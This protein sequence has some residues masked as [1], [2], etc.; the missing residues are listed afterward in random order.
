MSKSIFILENLNCANCAS[1]IEAKINKLPQTESA[2]FA[3]TTKKLTVESSLNAHELA[4]I[5][6]KVCD[7][8]EYGV[9]VREINENHSISHSH[10][11]EKHNCEC[12]DHSCGHTHDHG[13]HHEHGHSHNH[14]HSHSHEESSVKNDVLTII[15]GAVLFII[16]LILEHFFTLSINIPSIVAYILAYLVLGR[17]ILIKSG[18]NILKGQIFD[19]NFL[20]SIATL[21]AFAIQQ[22]PEA[23]G[24]MLFFR[25]G[26]LFEEIAVEKSRK[27]I[28]EA[29]DL[30]PETVRI[31]VGDEIKELPAEYAKVGDIIIVRPGDR[32][33]L[34]GTVTEGESTIDTSALTGESIPVSIKKS[35][36]VMS[37]CV[38][39]SD[40]IRIRV[41]KPL[42]ESMVTKILSAIEN[43]SAGKPKIDN[44]ITRFARVY[45][46]VVVAIAFITAF[47]IPLLSHQVFMPWI[48]TALSFLVMSCPCALVLSVPL[49]FFSGIGAG[50]K[51][52]ILFKDGLSMEALSKVK[53]VVMDKTGTLTKGNFEVQNV[54]A[55]RG[56]EKE[57]ISL[58]ASCEQESTHPIALSIVE[59]AKALKADMRKAESIKEISG[60]GIE[61]VI[62]GKRVLCGNKALMNDFG[63]DIS[64]YYESVYGTHVLVAAD[65]EYLGCIVISDSIKPD[66][67]KAVK[68]LKERHIFTAMLT[69]DNIKSAQNTANQLEIDDVHAGLLPQDK[70]S[71]LKKIR[72]KHGS[73]M[74]IGDGI[75]DAIVLAG[76]DVGAAMGSGAD[77]AIEAADVVF[78][79]SDTEAIPEAMEIA[80]TTTK[81]SRQN[82][83]FAI[84]VKI[85]VMILGITGIYS[86]MWLAVF[87][88]TGVAM[89]CIIN[90]IRIL[91]K[92]KF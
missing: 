54:T 52:G 1:K 80:Q 5:I 46:P 69:G 17:E 28:M 8:T 16:S 30:R 6:Q 13:H 43:A 23:V 39:T 41:D 64:L 60:K 91:F 40:L 37:G 45:T 34:D 51:K 74:F 57:L 71:E 20:M 21:G 18:K 79:N 15:T 3:F 82:I 84:A 72:E 4:E 10:A 85:I 53:A 58:C 50:S 29:V 27:S 67:A 75:N 59:Y 35:M 31:A 19:E 26:E 55:V 14:N 44:F 89:L 38:N 56:S 68:R 62:D 81:I 32:I 48:Y 49:A 12:S 2:V 42:S 88:D 92:N 47:V 70:L 65:G 22:F 83:V 9:I 77:A 76:A 61:A 87:A 24:V 36:S 33:P 78:M 25:I 63:I 7:S 66:A 73:V 11:E 90:S 86:S